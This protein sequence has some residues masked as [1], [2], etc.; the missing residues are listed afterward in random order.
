MCNGN[1]LGLFVID[2]GEQRRRTDST[3]MYIRKSQINDLLREGLKHFDGQDH[4]SF[5]LALPLWRTM[6]F[7]GNNSSKTSWKGNKCK[8]KEKKRNI[9]NGLGP[10]CPLKNSPVHQ[11][12]LL[13]LPL[14]AVTAYNQT[15]LLAFK[16]HQPVLLS[17]GDLL[18]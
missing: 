15:H 8:S 2:R 3:Q 13:I 9:N 18:F 14:K 5:L 6:F 10:N 16:P 7:H 11:N 4:L 1:I 17:H 12:I